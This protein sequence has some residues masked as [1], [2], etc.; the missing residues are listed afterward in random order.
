ML[1]VQVH[2]H[3]GT[4]DLDVRFDV[5]AREILAVHGPSGSGKTTLINLIAGLQ[6]PDGGRIVVDGRIL[7]DSAQRINIRPE[8]R[9]V[10]YVFQDCR[11]FPHMSV[12][13]NLRYGRHGG[14]SHV[15]FDQVVDLLDIRGLLRRR[16]RSLSGGESQRVA[17]GRALLSGPDLLLMDE[18]LASID[19]ERKAE[20]LPF[21]RRLRDTFALPIVYVSHAAEEI[22]QVADRSIR[23]ENGRLTAS[24]PILPS[25]IPTMP[26]TGLRL[27]AEVLGH[28]VT[29]GATV[30]GS[31]LGRLFV[32]RRTEP[33][34]TKV[35][36]VVGAAA[37]EP[38]AETEP[39]EV[40]VLPIR[41]AA[42]T[43]L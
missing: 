32:P 2:R 30:L 7:F 34:G 8:A 35:Q 22:T 23:I 5:E 28:D 43:R 14:R 25:G 16:P 31:S 17:I 10:G 21:I 12:A 37:V 6:R 9:H 33:P 27:I 4:F 20:I 18:P 24:Q 3:I 39:G 19:P 42:G 29:T 38:I 1:Q 11:L 40:A 15:D 26:D 41:A 13:A 36:V